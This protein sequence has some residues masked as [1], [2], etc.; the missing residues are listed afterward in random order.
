MFSC[1]NIS[2]HHTFSVCAGDG[3]ATIQNSKDKRGLDWNS[4]AVPLT[5]IIP[6]FP[7]PSPSTLNVTSVS[8][9]PVP[10]QLGPTIAV[11]GSANVAF[12]PVTRLWTLCCII[13]L[14]LNIIFEN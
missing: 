1:D 2:D 7:V 11:Q 5:L 14:G 10:T 9:I 6:K 8:D 4:A 12:P 13:S 3:I